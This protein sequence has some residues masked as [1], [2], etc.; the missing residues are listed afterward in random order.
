VGGA[1]HD[2]RSAT[3]YFCAS[4]RSARGWADVPSLPSARSRRTWRSHT[5]ATGTRPT[6]GVVAFNGTHENRLDPSIS[7]AVS[8]A[9]D[10]LPG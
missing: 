3:G 1:D 4:A 9:A 10:P 8:P 6:V 7:W 5:R 2:G